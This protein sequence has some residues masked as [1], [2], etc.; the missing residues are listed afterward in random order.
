MAER[1]GR[2]RT[3]R[4]AGWW[5]VP[6][7]E[8]A[9]AGCVYV[10]GG[11][12]RRPPRSRPPRSLRSRAAPAGDGGAGLSCPGGFFLCDGTG[13][14]KG[15]GRGGGAGAGA[16]GEGRGGRA[17]G[18]MAGRPRSLLP[19]L[20]ASRSSHRPV[21][22]VSCVHRARG[23]GAECWGLVSAG[24]SAP[25]LAWRALSETREVRSCGGASHGPPRRGHRP[26]TETDNGGL[27]CLC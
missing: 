26:E 22:G 3:N 6:G 17:A 7:S 15:T 23:R 12:C 1:R 16:A 4:D 18:A 20:T 21:A 8:R 13:P 14:G 25:P 10:C 9:L 19:S 11:R 2:V 27:R 24:L 5:E